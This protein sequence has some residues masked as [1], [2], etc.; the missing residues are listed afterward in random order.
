MGTPPRPAT[1]PEVPDLAVTRAIRVARPAAAVVP[2]ADRT[3]DRRRARL[4][5]PLQS[6]CLALDPV[7]RRFHAVLA[8]PVFSTEDASPGNWFLLFLN[9]STHD[10]L[11]LFCFNIISLLFFCFF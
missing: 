11:F 2:A 10:L 4:P 6:L 8:R 3:V 5:V 9:N 1:V 7:R